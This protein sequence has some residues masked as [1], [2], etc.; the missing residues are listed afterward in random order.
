M[1]ENFVRLLEKAKVE[2]DN[3]YGYVNYL[4]LKR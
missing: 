2:I 4:P 3:P 1:S